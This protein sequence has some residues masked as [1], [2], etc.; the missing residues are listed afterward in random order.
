VAI[1]VPL[2]LA[3]MTA[4]LRAAM[5]GDELQVGSRADLD[6]D[7]R[8]RIVRFEAAGERPPR[9]IERYLAPG[10]RR[11]YLFQAPCCDVFDALYD[12]DGRYICAP[13]GGFLGQGDGRCP[14]WIHVMQRYQ[15]IELHPRPSASTG[16]PADRQ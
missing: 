10:G 14:A 7:V 11:V 12:E 4:G 15:P 1:G 16:M 6:P 2:T 3:L 8:E 13:S 9:D 5:A